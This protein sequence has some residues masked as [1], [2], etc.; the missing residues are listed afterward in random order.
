MSEEADPSL[1]GRRVAGKFV[2]EQFLGGGSMGAVYRARDD[3]LDRK[4]ALKVMH[5]AMAVD[6]S[7]VSRFHREAR[8][9]SRLDH[10]SSV[11]VIEFGEEP[12][13]LL[14]MAMEY[15]EGREL[16]KVILE[17][18]PLSEER[19]ADV[20]MKAL[21]AIAA[22]HD[23][24]VIHR[25]LKPEN[26]MILD[27]K[28]D[29]GHDIVKVC[30]FGIA[31]I[32]EKDESAPDAAPKT[33]GAKLTTG[34]V[35][36]GTPE[37]MSPEQARGEKLDSRSDL[38]SMGIILYQLLTGRT[39]FLA[40][41]PLAVVLKQISAT[42]EP[43]R[44]IYPGVHV[45]L[46]AVC[47]R[48]LAKAKEERFQTAR[49]MRAALKAAIEGGSNAV[50]DTDAVLPGSSP[51]EAESKTLPNPAVHTGASQALPSNGTSQ[52]TPLLTALTAEDAPRSRVPVIVAL[53]LVALVVGGIAA[54]LAW[55]GEDVLLDASAAPATGSATSLSLDVKPPAPAAPASV[56][57]E[58]ASA[59]DAPAVPASASPEPASAVEETA[60]ASSGEATDAAT[61]PRATPSAT[62]TT[63]HEHEHEP[64]PA[65]EPQPTAAV[66]EP[67]P[68]AAPAASAFRAASCRAALGAPKSVSAYNVKDL[69][70]RGTDAA[71][72]S[73]AKS[74]LKAKPA[75]PIAGTVRI[76]FNDKAFRGATCTGCTPQLAQCI[77]ASTGKT[78]SVSFKSGKQTG[79][80]EFDVPVTFTCE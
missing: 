36:V 61:T 28:D 12:D 43:P 40:E 60:P 44:T 11:R 74:A 9:A 18:W 48:A 80:P 77:T 5:P 79:D 22:A 63:A 24:G 17:D 69:T 19:I 47:M 10:P 14:Y 32:T 56:S 38:Y 64:V 52:A 34:G 16:Y 6:P 20:I 76:R 66:P 49:D 25:D 41:T 55:K 7:F 13:G 46:E 15:L 59:V 30:D 23:M 8:A 62:Q 21:A 78:A 70:L 57:P 2:I 75:A 53:V 68:S 73:C 4:V 42:P 39:P 58:P 35:L 72:T 50:S 31:K 37:Y 54:V 51:R 45:G 27:R 29:E 33:A 67:A 71:W 3:S 65:P 1:I 26:I